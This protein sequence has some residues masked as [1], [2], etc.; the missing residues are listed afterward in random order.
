LLII[1]V[2]CGKRKLGDVNVDI[3]KNINPDIVA[4][5]NN[6]PFRDGVFDLAYC[7][8]VLEH[9][10]VKPVRAIKE[11]KRIAKRVEIEVPHYLSPN[12]KK[13][14]EHVNFEVMRRSWWAKNFPNCEIEIVARTIGLSSLIL[15]PNSLKVKL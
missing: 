2:G 1:D 5:I 6:L 11:L 8:H 3:N 4:D 14:K 13:D 10:S 12:A 15:L 9:V 7:Y